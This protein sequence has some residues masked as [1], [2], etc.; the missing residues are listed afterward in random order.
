MNAPSVL[1][2]W[3]W[4][5]DVERQNVGGQA[6]K[7]AIID[8]IR[9]GWV[10]MLDDDTVA[11]P[12]VLSTVSECLRRDLSLQAIIVGQRRNMREDLVADPGHIVPGFCDVGQA[13]LRRDLIG[14]YRIPIDYNGDGL[15]LHSVLK[16]NNRVA[17]LSDVLSFHNAISGV[18]VGV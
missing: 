6:V 17:Y 7:N 3:H 2:R 14:E 16:G 8:E 13:F 5:F 18:E 12:D 15:F 1:L 10:W 4:R 9:D 11:H